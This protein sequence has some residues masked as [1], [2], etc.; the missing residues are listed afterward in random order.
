MMR[1]IENTDVVPAFIKCTVM[2]GG[3]IVTTW[4][5]QLKKRSI[6]VRIVYGR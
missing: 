3:C 4:S 6:R 5:A 2:A 1:Y